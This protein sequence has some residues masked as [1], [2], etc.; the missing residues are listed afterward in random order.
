MLMNQQ[1]IVSVSTLVQQIKQTLEFNDGLRSF[2]VKGEISNFTAH[3]NG[4]WYF[5]LKDENAKIS[6]V[7]FKS[8]AS[9][10]DFKVKEGDQVLLRASIGVYALQGSLQCSVF[11]MQNIGLGNLYIQFEKLRKKLS[12]QGY[13]DLTHKK[14]IPL[15]PRKIAIIT[16]AKS[17]ALQDMFKMAHLR[18]PLVELVLYETLVQGNEAAKQMIKALNAADEEECDV[19]ILARGGGSIEDLWAF[20][21]EQL[22]MCIYNLKTPLVT[23]V[24]HESDITIVDYVADQRT[25]TPTA[26]MQFVLPEINSV[27][28]DINASAKQLYQLIHKSLSLSKEKLYRLQQQR[29]IKNPDTILESHRVNVELLRA[30]MLNSAQDVSPLQKQLELTVLRLFQNINHKKDNQK[31]ILL[32]NKEYLDRNIQQNIKQ[33]KELFRH[34]L[35]LLNA[36]SPLNSLERGYSLTYFKDKLVQSIES[37]AINDE[38][39]IHIKD[40]IIKTIVQSKEK[41]DD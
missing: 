27:L 33:S 22:A 7:M 15:Y 13:F 17:A 23:G 39:T 16:G 1:E 29:F 31:N 20:N 32:K 3:R 38:L 30:R 8:Y 35:A 2:Y 9:A 21:D 14:K 25:A 28:E 24:G 6:C 12:D 19:L 34:Q 40:G 10:V 4:H 36:Y 37:V 26:A 41:K 11:S 5:S 18:W